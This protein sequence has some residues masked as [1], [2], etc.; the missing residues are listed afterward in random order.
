MDP[1]EQI[2]TAV[3]YEGYVL[4]PYRRS[5]RKNQQRWTLGGVYPRAFS[6]AAGTRDP[7]RMQTQCLVRGAA[8]TV[9]VKVRFLQVVDRQ[10]GR[11]CADGRLEFVDALQVGSERYLAWE[12]ATEREVVA[13]DLPLRALAAPRSVPIVVPAGAA[14]EPLI[15]PDGAAVGA[16][17]RRWRALQG[18]VEIGAEPL[19]E[20]LFRLTVQV[21]N[22][23][24]WSGEPRAATLQ[25]T[26]ASAHTLLTLDAGEFLSLMD[27]PEE[28][29]WAAERCEN[30]Q[31][32][33][34]LVGP[35]GDRRAM[36]SAPIILYDYPQVAPESPGDL[37]D[38]TE[39]D[40]LLIL[41]ILSLTDEEKA[42]VRASDARARALLERTEALT[43]ED[44]LRLHGAIR[45]FQALDAEP[46]SVP[47]LRE[48]EQP[49]PAQVVVDG[50]ALAPGSRVRLRPRPGG[51][52]LDLALAGKLAVVEAIEQDYEGRIHLAVVLEDDP[53]RDLG[54]ARQPGHRFFFAPQEIEPVDDR[55]GGRP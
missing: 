27:P 15:G 16:L 33:P 47:L 48:L 44:F 18:M 2:A 9:S 17:V 31:T 14:E 50:V 39:I 36:L 49:P 7:W 42:E 11:W 3:L 30:I 54:V 40:Q 46:A 38:N 5:A 4:W 21:S 52:I 32:W 25:Q 13:A 12:E 45:E 10:V 34:V 29:R 43:P 53:G 24:P 19:Q 35:P 41:N 55:A 6:E 8:P 1:V 22:T 26:F 37:F 28:L 23:T 51:D 20:A